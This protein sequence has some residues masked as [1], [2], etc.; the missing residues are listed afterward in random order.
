[1]LLIIDGKK[2][3]LKKGLSFDFV[4]ENRSFSDADNYTLS[5][6]L[7]L[8]GCPENIAIFGHINRMDIDTRQIVLEASIIDRAI[9]KQG[10]VTVVEISKTEVKCQFLEGRSG[11][12]FM[13]T[14]DDIY[15][16][17]LDLGKYPTDTLPEY[18]EI[19]LG[20]YEHH[21]TQVALPWVYNETGKIQNEMIYDSSGTLVWAEDTIAT[22]KLS[23]QPYL[24]AITERICG[25][26][27]Y[28]FDFSQWESSLKVNLL[29]CNTLPAAWD[30]PQYAR[31]LPHWTVTE[32]FEELEKILVCEFEIDHKVKHISV[33]MMDAFNPPEVTIPSMNLLD[34]FSAEVAYGENLC[35]F[36]GVANISY[37]DR[38]D[39]LW[40]LDSCQWLID[41]YKQEGRYYKEFATEEE[42]WNWQYSTFGLIPLMS[43]VGERS[44]ESGLL[45]YIAEKDSY[46]IYR[47][48]YANYPDWPN[49]YL[50]NRY[51]INRFGELVREPNSDNEIELQII[52]VRIDATDAAH[53]Y[54]LSLTPSSYSEGPNEDED[55]VVQPMAYSSLL[56]GEPDTSPE[57]YSKLYVAYWDGHGSN[58]FPTYTDA[59]LPPCP[60][61]DDM[62]SLSNLY[63]NYYSGAKIS[64]R[65]KVAFSWLSDTM[66][67]PR[68]IFHIRGK[69][70]LC[71]KI[72]ATFTEKGMSQLL[73]GEFYPLLDN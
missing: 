25:A 53:G 21:A 43:K 3:V 73:K 32:F 14:F 11:Q 10:I 39:S 67:N 69:R 22:G 4:A 63:G 62:F 18:P 5:I 7:P 44:E 1:M 40:A 56:N 41:L 60:S 51:R 57:Y 72:T 46:Y 49:M 30:I 68:A 31:A 54:C 13:T 9:S 35:Q 36:K 70:Y 16:N 17:E 28:T 34:E 26:L 59:P 23:F 29:I 2:A 55:G 66:P 6:S 15:I 52:P 61:V 12:N 38:G 27:G 20:D 65:E 71:E 19:Y 33:L 45:M 8:A 48:E 64:A 58:P 42:F 24:I 47:V 37:S 50:L